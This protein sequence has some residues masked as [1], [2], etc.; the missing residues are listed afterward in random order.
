L[1]EHLRVK[2][3]GGRRRVFEERIVLIRA[4]S[5]AQAIRE[6]ER[7]ARTY[8]KDVEAKYLKF[9]ETYHLYA[10]AVRSGTEVFSLMRSS[11]MI[12]RRFVSRYFDDGSEHRRR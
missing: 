2:P 6:A 11:N 9:V 4:S 12:P 1:F 3:D 8:A 10:A 5:E 7:E